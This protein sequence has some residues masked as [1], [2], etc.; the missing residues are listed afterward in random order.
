MEIP[1][2]A[3]PTGSAMWDS[4]HRAVV[5]FLNYLASER[6]YSA[7]TV[8]HYKRDLT[9]LSAYCDRHAVGDWRELTPAQA[10]A[11]LADLHRRGLS[12]R[13][14]QRALSAARSF[15]RYLLREGFTK[16]SPIA[17]LA[18]PR[19]Q[20]RLPATLSSDEAVKLVQVAGEDGLAARDR[21]LLELLYSSGLRLSEVTALNLNDLD[22]S[23]G[24][25]R[26]TGK[27]GKTRI[28]PVG[29]HACAAL[30][31]W[32]SLRGR[33]ASPGEQ[34][35]FVNRRGGR[36]GARSVQLRLRHWAQRQGIG[37]P[38]HPHVLR[39]SFAT[40]LLESGG[41]LRAVQELLGHANISTTQIYTHLDFQ[42]LAKVYDQAHPRAR[43]KA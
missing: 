37:R 3:R 9:C 14:I 16:T 15:Y 1:S 5:E 43:K 23:G 13:T 27:G 22:L 41:D 6:R 30:R 25:V 10:R 29:S 39:H 35:V 26:V 8:A 12:G 32:F 40:H 31:R 38:V 36:L 2:L 4:A 18:P 28:V 34:A 19:S 24:L 20:R 11:F 7:H 17:G 21:A 33:L 42:H